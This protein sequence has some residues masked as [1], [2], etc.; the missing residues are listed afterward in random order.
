MFL[1]LFCS[2]SVQGSNIPKELGGKKERCECW[3][4]K[5]PHTHPSLPQ[6]KVFL[7]WTWHSVFLWRCMFYLLVCETFLV[8]MQGSVGNYYVKVDICFWLQLSD[9]CFC[10]GEPWMRKAFTDSDD[11]CLPLVSKFRWYLFALQYENPKKERG[12]LLSLIVLVINIVTALQK[13]LN[14]LS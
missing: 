3:I 14:G 11:F 2:F 12:W 6:K 7:P 9:D 8:K 4:F 13:N 10:D 5:I 1:M